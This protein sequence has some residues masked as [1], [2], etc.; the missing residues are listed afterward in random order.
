MSRSS[1]WG[2]G[3]LVILGFCGCVSLTR[4]VLYYA[5]VPYDSTGKFYISEI[6]FSQALCNLKLSDSLQHKSRCSKIRTRLVE[7]GGGVFT[8]NPDCPM[9]MSIMIDASKLDEG[10]KGFLQTFTPSSEDGVSSQFALFC[11]MKEWSLIYDIKIKVTSGNKTLEISKKVNSHGA[12]SDMFL[13]P[14]ILV[15]LFPMPGG[16]VDGFELYPSML[17]GYDWLVEKEFAE[18]VKSAVAEFEL[19][20]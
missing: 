6:G 11:W 5:Q 9:H 14:G 17:D 12:K 2:F 7:N 16:H 15:M 8:A 20:Q 10:G 13:Y 1:L 3:L 4:N 19:V 18:V